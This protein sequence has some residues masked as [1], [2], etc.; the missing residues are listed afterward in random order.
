MRLRLLLAVLALCAAGLAAFAVSSVLLLNQSM[1]ARAD[2]QLQAMAGGLQKGWRA[3]EP[4]AGDDDLPT[5]FTIYTYDE[6]GKLLWRA[7]TDSE[8]GPVVPN[9][10]VH[11]RSSTPTTV[12][13]GDSDS[14]WRAI[15]VPGKGTDRMVVAISLVDLED[16]VHRLLLI[17]VAVGAGI[18][19]LVAAVGR[20]VVRLGLRPLTRMEQTATAISAGNV[21]LRVADS[22]PRTETG[23]LGRALNTMLTRLGTAMRDR[24]SSEQRLRRFV[25]D[26]SHELRT[27][28]TSIRGFAELYQHGEAERDPAV[29]RILGRIE[30]EAARMGG[31]VDDLLL[32]ARLDRE[33]ALDL[34]DVDLRGLVEDVAQDA[35]ARHPDRSVTVSAPPLRMHV[36][37]DSHRLYQ[38]VANLVG[39]ALTH[40]PEGEV[41][42][43]LRPT[44]TAGESL[45]A[46]EIEVSD[47]GPGIAAEHLPYLFDRFYRADPARSP[48]GR[49][50]GLA[51]SA[52]LV[53]AHDGRISVDSKLGSGTSFRVVL[54]VN[55]PGHGESAP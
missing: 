52:A 42:V 46:I 41:R 27:P 43:R 32:L 11:D 44:L 28:L 7:P 10:L 36:L 49:G 39:N 20:V 45:P 40:S 24:E 15:S 12:A 1:T 34:S 29:E 47:D 2:G 4:Q 23:S 14:S 26:A 33:P 22:D 55:G 3:P 38:V 50:L 6:S 19:V 25:A 8:D 51:I 37:G 21:E 13:D 31:M 35:L 54:P 53:E 16:T 30:D 5:D 18:L 9:A 17:E 48:G